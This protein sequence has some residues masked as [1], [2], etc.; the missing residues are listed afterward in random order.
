MCR[1]VIIELLL[2]YKVLEHI[3]L[4]SRVDTSP[5]QI[6]LDRSPYRKRK[7]TETDLYMTRLAQDSIYRKEK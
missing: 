1:K 3:H 2:D 4:Y 5:T 7:L 6:G